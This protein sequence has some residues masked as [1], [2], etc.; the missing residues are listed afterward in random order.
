MIFTT[1]FVLIMTNKSFS[2]FKKREKSDF[3]NLMP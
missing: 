3:L 1:K 2:Y